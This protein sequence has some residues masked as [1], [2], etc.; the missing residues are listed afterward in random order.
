[1]YYKCPKSAK[2][3]SDGQGG[4]WLLCDT[5]TADDGLWRLW[6]ANTDRERKYY[7]YPN[8]TRMVSDGQSFSPR[9]LSLRGKASL[10]ERQVL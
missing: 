10:R 5:D 3:V 2:M 8:S 9:E 7:K 4:V 6:H 1:M